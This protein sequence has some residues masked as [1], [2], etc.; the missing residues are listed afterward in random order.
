MIKVLLHTVNRK[1]S[2]NE[3]FSSN[4]FGA[5]GYPACMSL[6]KINLSDPAGITVAGSTDEDLGMNIAPMKGEEIG[7]GCLDMV[8]F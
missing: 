1:D 7:L 3:G 6:L 8:S 4:D 5:F 2:F